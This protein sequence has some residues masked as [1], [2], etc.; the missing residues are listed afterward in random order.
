MFDPEL[1]E[2]TQK[3][4][5]DNIRQRTDDQE[6]F[7]SVLGLGRH[8]GHKCGEAGVFALRERRLDPAAR[9]VED[10]D[11]RHMLRAEALCG[12]GQIKLDDLRR[13]GADEEQRFDVRAAC[14]QARD[15]AVKFVLSIDHTR[16]IALFHDRRRKTRFGKDHHTRRRL[17]EVRTGARADHEEEGV[18]H[19]TVKPDDTGEAA[20]NLTLS[21]LAQDRAG[22]IA[23]A[24]GKSGGGVH[25]STASGVAPWRRAMRNFQRNC[26]ALTT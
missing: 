9:I 18:L 7:G 13:T 23:V 26:A 5:F 6:M 19:L 3:L 15:N 21:A 11:L 16:Q 1:I 17:Q 8:F 22:R 14:K 10:A 25:A 2:K 4:V 20:E 12:L 24:A